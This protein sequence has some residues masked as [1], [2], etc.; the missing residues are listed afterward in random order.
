M[1][2]SIISTKTNVY[3]LKFRNS[4]ELY[5]FSSD[6]QLNDILRLPNIKYGI[7]KIKVFNNIGAFISVSKKDFKTWF[8]Y[9]TEAMEVLKF[10]NF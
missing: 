10:V 2:N 3:H 8:S 4:P 5:F 1:K 9:N 6:E 7:E